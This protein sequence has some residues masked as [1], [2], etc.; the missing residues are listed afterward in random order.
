MPGMDEIAVK[1]VIS[2][3]GLQQFSLFSLD[4][5]AAEP[6]SNLYQIEKLR[7]NEVAIPK[8]LVKMIVGRAGIDRDT[9]I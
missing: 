4:F 3:S 6:T 1:E 5:F 2:F 7:S 9:Y 8:L